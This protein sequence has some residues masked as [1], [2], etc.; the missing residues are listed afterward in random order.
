MCFPMTCGASLTSLFEGIL[1]PDAG[2]TWGRNNPPTPLCTNR[3]HTG[4][5]RHQFGSPVGLRE[6]TKQLTPEPTCCHMP[7]FQKETGQGEETRSSGHF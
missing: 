2:K 3:P 7:A 4:V 1:R 6:S 5:Y